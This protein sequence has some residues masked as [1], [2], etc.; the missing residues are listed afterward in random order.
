MPHK[1]TTLSNEKDFSIFDDDLKP[2]TWN[3]GKYKHQNYFSFNLKIPEVMPEEFNR[4]ISYILENSGMSLRG[5][6]IDKYKRHY[7]LILLNLARSLLCKQ[8]LLIPLNTAAYKPGSNPH[9][10]GFNLRYVKDIL[11]TLYEAELIHAKKGKKY[12]IQPQLTAIQPA[13]RFGIELCLMALESTSEFVGDY[14]FLGKHNDGYIP[15]KLHKEQLIQDQHDM[16]IINSFLEHHSWPMKGPMKRI[17]S[18]EVGLS[19]RIYCDFQAIPKRTVRIRPTSL[20]DGFPIAEVDIKCSHPR[21]AAQI[22]EGIK[23]SRNFYNDVSQDTDVFISK[24]KDYFRVSLSSSNR[25]K[26]LMAFKDMDQA[27][28]GLDFNILEQW[29]VHNLPKIPLYS[30]WSK[31]AMNIEGEIIKNVMLKGVY[32]EKVVL[33]I[34]DAIAVKLE[35]AEWGANIMHEAWVEVMGEDYCEVDI[36]Y[37]DNFKPLN[38]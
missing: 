13:E 34:H 33:P 30:G 19:G 25:Q 9:R 27:N 6:Y 15:T 35:D 38:P 4:S 12:A 24:V 16:S 11:G 17:Y 26:A 23:L 18:G 36:D 3:L 21:L 22:F 2:K 28:T 5:Q 32:E 29:M 1:V 20:I 7:L 37:P 8:W 14:A 31:V 10:N